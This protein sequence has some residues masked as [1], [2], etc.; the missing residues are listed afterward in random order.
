[1]LF[2]RA[3]SHE[4]QKMVFDAHDW[5]FGLFKGTCQRAIYNN[6]KDGRLAWFVSVSSRC[7]AGSKASDDD[8]RYRV[9][10]ANSC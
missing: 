4:M 5:A 10:F 3:Y 1:M 8:R 9:S 7:G 6:M 2:V